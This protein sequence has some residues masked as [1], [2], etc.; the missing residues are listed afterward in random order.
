MQVAPTEVI[1]KVTQIR[2]LPSGAIETFLTR[3]GLVLVLLPDDAEIPGS[4]WGAPEAGLIG[5]TI[6]ARP[7]T[8]VH[9]ILH[10]TCHW[11]CMTEERR[12]TAHT[13]A[14]G[15]DIEE[16]A[17]C[18]LECLLADEIDGYNQELVFTDMDTWGYNFRLGSAREWFERDA[19][20]AEKWLIRNNLRRLTLR[21]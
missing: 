7:D 11:L 18:Y 16:V 4:Y 1:P 8:P 10:T 12:A 17:V 2:D 14:G 5:N 20:D 3:H 19:E 13:N 9:S 15:D 21:R 6:H